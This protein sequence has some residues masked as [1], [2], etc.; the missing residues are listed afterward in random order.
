[1]AGTGPANSFFARAQRDVTF[2]ISDCWSCSFDVAVKYL[3]TLPAAQN[4]GS[5]STQ[6][7]PGEATIILLARWVDVNTATNWNA[8]IIWF[9]DA[10][11]QL[12]EQIPDP[13]FQNLSKDEWYRWGFKFDLG[14]NQ[15]RESCISFLSTGETYTYLPTNRY[16][17]GG[18]AGA[19]P[20]TGFRLFAGA[21]GGPEF[22]GT[23][24]AFDN[25]DIH[26]SGGCPPTSFS[27]F[28]GTVI[29]AQLSDFVDSDDVRARFNPGFVLN[30]AEAP[31]WLIFDANCPTAID[32][33]LESNAGT[34][35][36]T[37]TVEAWN[38][39][40]HE[41]DVIGQHSE[42]Y[43]ADQVV[44]FTLTAN[45]IDSGGDVRSRVGWRKTGFTINF[46]WEVRIDQVGWNP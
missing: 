25:I 37:Y 13:H 17:W 42:S 14:T 36:L 41:Y 34:P 45:H 39:I 40:T 26:P 6:L 1:V 19:P 44:S 33:H 21:S 32:F 8:D 31:V 46:P 11:N 2:A 20:P 15:V 18:A 7:F 22:A 12:T 5:F 35:G 4:V 30:S 24:L 3:G 23:T 10:G 29:S 27:T 28:R 38:W 16:L 9:D 43:N